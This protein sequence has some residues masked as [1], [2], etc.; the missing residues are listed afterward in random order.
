MIQPWPAQHS[1]YVADCR[2]FRV[3][4]D[5]VASPRTGQTH[6]M[7][8]LEHPNWVNI[9]PLTTRNEVVLVRQWRHGTRTMRTVSATSSHSPPL[10]RTR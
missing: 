5:S 10:I 2:I 4:K 9:V 1:E 3:R 8:V 7:F 6:D